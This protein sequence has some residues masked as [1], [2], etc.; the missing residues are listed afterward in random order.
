MSAAKK[1]G[2]GRSIRGFLVG[3]ARWMK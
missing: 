2:M 1:S 3:A